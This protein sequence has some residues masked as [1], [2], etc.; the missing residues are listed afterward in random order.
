M[1][2]ARARAAALPGAAGAAALA[3]PAVRATHV[4]RPMEGQPSPYGWPSTSARF[5]ASACCRARGALAE[6]PACNLS[7][8]PLSPAFASR[9]CLA[10]ARRLPRS[11]LLDASPAGGGH[12]IEDRLPPWH[13][14]PALLAV[15]HALVWSFAAGAEAF[16]VSSLSGLLSGEPRALPARGPARLLQLEEAASIGCARYLELPGHLPSESLARLVYLDALLP[17]GVPILYPT[18]PPRAG[19]GGGGGGGEGESEGLAAGLAARPPPDAGALEL[20]LHFA[21]TELGAFAS[22]RWLHAG[23]SNHV[24]AVR[25]LHLLTL[26]TEPE[27]LGAP[28]GPAPRLPRTPWSHYAPTAAL[29]ERVRG[30]AQAALEAA[31]GEAGACALPL[32]AAP[33]RPRPA[34]GAR[35]PLRPCIALLSRAPGAQRELLNEEDLARAIARAHPGLPLLRLRPAA[36]GDLRGSL[37]ALSRATLILAPHGAGSLNALAAPP[38]AA[39][40]E[41]GPSTASPAFQPGAACLARSVGLRYFFMLGESQPGSHALRVGL[42]EALEL[43][44]QALAGAQAARQQADEE[45]ARVERDAADAMG[46]ELEDGLHA[47]SESRSQNGT[48]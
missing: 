40:L 1:R 17:A 29:A 42:E 4:L 46:H 14:P 45:D 22:R 20:W 19:G 30:W 47:S 37:L 2:R 8:A 41:I 44:A 28:D 31:P 33:E 11:I 9:E 15:S 25:R 3:D 38:G 27:P 16:F 7:M 5:A 10:R 26:L 13:A 39:L 18:P 6:A 24:L 48:R 36:G 23:R 43:V 12:P 21:R 35:L 34:G 32:G